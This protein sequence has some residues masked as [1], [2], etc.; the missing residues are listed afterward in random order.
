M[1]I[2]I[3]GGAGFIG[4]HLSKHL[5]DRGDD[6]VICDNFVRGKKDA[7]L[8]ELLNRSNVNLIECDLSNPLNLEK[9]GSG[10]DY[11]YHMASINHTGLFYKIPDE[12]LRVGILTSINI[13]DWMKSK[14][15]EGKIMFTS[16]NEAYAGALHSFDKLLIPTPENVP[17]VISDTYNPRWSYAGTKL[18]GELLFI[19]YAKVHNFRMSIVRP[20]NFYGPRAG[21]GHVIPD[22]IERILAK[23]SPFNIYGAKDT[24]SFC[25]IDDAIEQITA[26]MESCKTDGET[27]H[28]G[29]SEEILIEDLAKLLFKIAGYNQEII[30][31]DSPIGSVKRR[32]SDLSKLYDLLGIKAKIGL[33]EGLLRTIN[34]YKNNMN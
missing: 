23:E 4:Y 14:N 13:L 30:I 2:L 31:H 26:V 27:I 6:V 11:I 10:Y 18:I 5:A 3:T 22:F 33:E 21:A 28:L 9:I 24:R 15:K 17:L 34:W 1:K 7:E 29:N 19:N 32:C 12:I 16:S 8:N 25:Y 20:H